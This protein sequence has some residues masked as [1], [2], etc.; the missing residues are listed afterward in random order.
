[1]K[2]QAR[3]PGR[4]EGQPH[5]KLGGVG[6]ATGEADQVTP[7]RLIVRSAAISDPGDLISR[8]PEPGS[9][10]W[11]HRGE[12]IV[13]WGVA[14]RI[15]LPAGHDRF[16]A[17]QKWLRALFDG[18][19]VADDVRRP[20]SGPIAFGS[21]T[22][23]PASD[24]SVLVVPRV[25]IGRRRGSS[26]L[27]TID[28]A[29]IGPRGTGPAGWAAA[30]GEPSRPGS[31]LPGQLDGPSAPASGLLPVPVPFVPPSGVRW[32]DG[33][34]SAPRWEL[35]VASAVARIGAGE[36]SK[37]VL[38]RDLNATAR[39]DIDDRVLLARLAERYPDCYTYSCS[40]LVGSSPDLLIRREG[41]DVYSR[42]LAG[43]APRGGTPA[44]DDELGAGLLA[45][46]KNLREH[47]FAVAGERAVLEPLCAQVSVDPEPTLLRLSN[48]Q[49]LVTRIGGVLNP[50]RTS[51]GSAL[52]LAAALHPTPA[53]GGTPT[54]AALELIRELEGMDRGRYAGPV[55][56]V[57]AAGN[58]EWAIALRCGLIDGK[59]ARLFAGGGIVAG[60]EPASELAEAQAKFRPMCQ[61]LEG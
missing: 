58:G 15:T 60:S 57:D 12:G 50:A 55:G 23:D 20:G 2:Q 30:D 13:A 24:G 7:D 16:E 44:D 54:E 14:A 59:N 3:S 43:T 22:F 45:S 33:S 17:G 39:Q 52:S 8:L 1:M 34:L 11:V 25:V 61:A 49:H 40:G 38:A 37:V 19:A 51:N 36:L 4:A 35:A 41:K 21:F 48:V 42:V 47:A 10:A 32:S 46:A 26:W 18:A 6:W 29:A 31:P 27:T 56:W 9:L 53:V 5:V 28:P